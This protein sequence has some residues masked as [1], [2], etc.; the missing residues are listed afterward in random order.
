LAI[1]VVCSP[2]DIPRLFGYYYLKRFANLAAQS[3]HQVTFLRT[4]TLENFEK[5]LREQNPEFVIMNGHGGRLGITGQDDNVILGLKGYDSLLGTEIMDQNPELMAGRTVFLLTCNAGLELAPSLINYGAKATVS[6][7]APFIFV[8]DGDD[9]SKEE[10]GGLFFNAALQLPIR[11]ING[12]TW[13]ESFEYMKRAF[14]EEADRAEARG[15]TEAAKYL[16]YDMAK[17]A[18]FGNLAAKYEST[19]SVPEVPLERL[20]LPPPY[21]YRQRSAE[22]R[23]DVDSVDSDKGTLSVR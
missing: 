6:F 2:D 3:G 1:L 5:L 22:I 13:G 15:D 7:M 17:A 19:L 8:S 11:Y 16:N 23:R 10:R 18:V 20:W 9:P 14:D 4:A 21:V 12:Y